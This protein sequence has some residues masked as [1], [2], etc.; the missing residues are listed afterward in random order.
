MNDQ[1]IERLWRA[2]STE[3]PGE[4]IDAVIRAAARRDLRRR[5]YWTR[6][7]P[8]AAAASV[9]VIAIL[10]VRQS[11]REDL[12]RVA[13]VD[14]QV[15][16]EEAL[17]EPAAT[18]SAETE[19]AGAPAAAPAAPAARKLAP[20]APEPPMVARDSAASPAVPSTV[21][22]ASDRPSGAGTQ[23]SA[24]MRARVPAPAAVKA[25]AAADAHANGET[26]ALPERLIELITADAA[27]VAQIDPRDVR[28]LQWESVTWSD[29]SLGC[30]TPGEMAIQVLT[31][32]YR[33]QVLAGA[34]ALE[35]HTDARDLVRLCR[36]GE[37][38]ATR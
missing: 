23:R 5:P 15:M 35:Y 3:T 9:G 8:L 24:E 1:D 27:A 7:A 17:G 36:Q 19:A 11:P 31:P 16:T 14:A 28:I 32:G 25:Q 2:Q 29:G 13:P 4:R 30:R 34:L 21:Q 10:L 18:Q 12:T 38:P 22:S 26:P 37:P 20:P 33:V 6:Y